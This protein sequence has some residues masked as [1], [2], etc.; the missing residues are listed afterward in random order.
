MFLNKFSSEGLVDTPHISYDEINN[1]KIK[2]IL[3]KQ[4]MKRVFKGE[5]S[6]RIRNKPLKNTKSLTASSVL[7]NSQFSSIFLQFF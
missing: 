5:S 3:Y 2:K 6:L 4:G 1:E 7:I